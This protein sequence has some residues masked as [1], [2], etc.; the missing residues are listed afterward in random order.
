MSYR[1][2]TASAAQLAI[3]LELIKEFYIGE[4]LVYSTKIETTLSQLLAEPIYGKVLLAFDENQ[5]IAYCVLTF[6]FSLEYHG[7]YLFIDEIF[8]VANYRRQKIGELLIFEAQKMAV[9]LSIKSIQLEV[10]H[11]NTKAQEFY[12]RLGFGDHGRFLLSREVET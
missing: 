3:I 12:R 7:R 11:E 10:D 8:V 2:E 9:D 5:A 4:G 1:V 6:G